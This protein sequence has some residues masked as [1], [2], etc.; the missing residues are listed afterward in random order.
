MAENNIWTHEETVKVLGSRTL[1][2]QIPELRQYLYSGAKVLDVGCGPGPVAV[3]VAAEVAPGFV[4]GVDLEPEAIDRANELAR[5]AHAGNVAFQVG[6]AH[7]LEFKDDNFD[8]TYSVNA[9]EWFR[10]PARA[11]K[12][13]ARVTKPGGRVIARTGE[14]GGRVFY[15]SRPAFENYFATFPQLKD[16][17][18][19]G[20]FFYPYRGR[21]VLELFSQAGLEDVELQLLAPGSY[22]GAED[23]ASVVEFESLS[24]DLEGPAAP[25]L[26]TRIDMGMLDEE[27]VLTMQQEL[28]AWRSH[29]HAFVMNGQVVGVGT[30]P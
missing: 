26:R 10:D 2:S 21:E 18:D 17:P 23:F 9:L 14:A 29:P 13:L 1:E 4:D 24:V 30:V 11:V 7:N 16:L 22:A 5:E 12:E 19:N 28:E 8:I 15:P 20:T 27:T 3:E 6:D 25:L